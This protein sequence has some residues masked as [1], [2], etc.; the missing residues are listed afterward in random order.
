MTSS[1]GQGFFQVLIRVVDV[2]WENF[3]ALLML[4]L[5]VIIP[6]Q[7]FC[8]FVLQGSLDWP[9]E[10]SPYLLAWIT[11][12]AAAIAMNNDEH[13][14]FDYVVNKVGAKSRV[15]IVLLGKGIVLFFL[16]VLLFYSVPIVLLKW[17]DEAYT[18]KLSKGLIYLCIPVGTAAL[19]IITV[20]KTIQVIKEYRENKEER[21]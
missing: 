4:A 13:V 1:N 5:L 3:V 12:F 18:M 17:S 7:V 14:S 9:D 6:L 2:I 15:F 10:L 20:K 16:F 19:F 11:F 8:R 21:R